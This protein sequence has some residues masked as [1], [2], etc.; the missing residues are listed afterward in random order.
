[1][2]INVNC[3]FDDKVRIAIVKI[4][5]IN[6]IPE[7][8]INGRMVRCRGLLHRDDNCQISYDTWSGLVSDNSE[9]RVCEGGGRECVFQNIAESK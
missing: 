6:S 1:M 4:P 5:I 8:M 3:M 7:V 2:V 9:R